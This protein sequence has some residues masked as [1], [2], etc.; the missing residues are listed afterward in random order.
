MIECIDES[1]DEEEF[2]KY[3]ENF[4]LSS[5]SFFLTY[6]KCS[7]D[8]NTFYILFDEL[9]E[10]KKNKIDRCICC[11]EDHKDTDGRHIHIFFELQKKIKVKNSKYFDVNYNGINYHPNVQKP[12]DKVGVI[13]YIAGLTKKKQNDKKN[14]FQFNIDYNDYL[15]KRKQHKKIN[16][17]DQLIKKKI[18]IVEAVNKNPVFIKQY[19][20]LKLNLLN[21]WNDSDVSNFGNR[22]CYWIYG[23]PGLGKSFSVRKKYPNFY[24]KSSTKWWDG[25]VDQSVV[26]IDDFDSISLSHYLKIWG[27][28][29]VFYGEVKGGTVLCKYNL[30]FITS[31]YTIEDIF[32]DNKNIVYTK[33]LCQALK[34]RFIEIDAE[35]YLENGFFNIEKI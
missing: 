15:L 27:D 4:N 21:Y 19:R 33:L 14:I 8:Q 2:E 31:N 9:I 35:C 18:T 29:Y 12:K 22:K 25:Y 3:G 10:K 16:I 7:I 34:R 28:V 24:L 26:L 20:D 30:L 1:V 13:K 23:K 5:K 6:P 17:Y 32:I 11:S